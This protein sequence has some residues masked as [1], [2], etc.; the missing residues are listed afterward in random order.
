MRNRDVRGTKLGKMF[1]R[2]RS[3][4]TN[5]WSQTKRHSGVRPPYVPVSC[6]IRG[7][8]KVTNLPRIGEGYCEGS[9]IRS[10][11]IRV[12]TD[13]ATVSVCPVTSGV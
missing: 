7:S 8:G 6:Q 3:L 12:V 2:L 1:L 13:K 5:G 11:R 9:W 10:I 4:A